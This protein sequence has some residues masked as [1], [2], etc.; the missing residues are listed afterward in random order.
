MPEVGRKMHVA[1][2]EGGQKGWRGNKKGGGNILRG[3][4][5]KTALGL[6]EMGGRGR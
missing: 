5:L 6:A 1:S 2:T 4:T 3:Q